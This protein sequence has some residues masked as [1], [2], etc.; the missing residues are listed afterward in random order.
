MYTSEFA[1]K[2]MPGHIRWVNKSAFKARLNT[3]DPATSDIDMAMQEL[4]MNRIILLPKY[5]LSS[6]YMDTNAGDT[7]NR[8]E[9]IEMTHAMMNKWGKYYDYN[10]RKNTARINVDR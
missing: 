9:H 8:S 4:L 3:E 6:A 5:F 1:F 10:Y 2:G 7:Q